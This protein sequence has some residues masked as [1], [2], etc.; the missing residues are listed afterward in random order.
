M[1][2][3][4]WNAEDYEKHSLGQQKWAK[5]LLAK[6]NLKGTEKILDLGCGD[7]KITVEIAKR[8]NSGSV[9]GVD[10][11]SAMIDLA[12]RHYPTN[13]YPNLSFKVMDATNLT[14]E[15]Y[16]DVIF[17]NATLHWVKNHKPV[18]DGLYRSLKP[19]GKILLQM[20]GKGNAATILQII[21]EL[22][23]SDEW[24]K[25]FTNFEFPYGFLSVEE[26]EMLL[27]T[28]GFS[29]NRV[30]L[31]PKDMVHDGIIGLEGWIRTTWLP[32][33]KQIPE[34][35]TAQFISSISAKYIKRIPIDS[36]GKVH[37]SMIRIEVDAIKK[38][39]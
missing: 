4:I 22:Q 38:D 18:V 5:E 17:S 20:G 14:F 9:V 3:Y 36:N 27:N 31:I 32:Y 26:Y 6:L 10:N 21:E 34:E 33:T 15:E 13:K 30:E 23:T 25:Y 37:V 29:I 8:L 2:K 1:S 11:S 16:F 24:E 28:S 19:N 39:S 12:T 35:K 7:G